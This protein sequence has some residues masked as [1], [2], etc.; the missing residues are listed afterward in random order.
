MN[1]S[2]AVLLVND[3]IK[4]VKGLYQ[5]DGK[6]GIFKTLDPTLKVDDYAV[7][8]SSTRWSITTVKI[9]EIDTVDIDFDSSEQLKWV[10]QKINM[11]GHQEVKKMEAQ[12]IDIIKKGELRKRREDIKKNTLDAFCAGEI[13]NLGI[14][15]LG[16]PTTEG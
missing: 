4:V 5:E 15:R 8:E 2:T 16:A 3:K 12:A 10:V 11:N 14:A 7:V 9:T 6:P 1:Y 13:D